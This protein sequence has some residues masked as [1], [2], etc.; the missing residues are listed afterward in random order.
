MLEKDVKTLF[1]A[2]VAV[3]GK[4]IDLCLKLKQ[5]LKIN[6]K[7]ESMVVAKTKLEKPV[8]IYEVADKF[9]GKKNKLYYYF[10]KPIDKNQMELL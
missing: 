6:Y 8:R 2:L 7:K 1:G 3:Q 5:D 10:W 4:Y 9:T